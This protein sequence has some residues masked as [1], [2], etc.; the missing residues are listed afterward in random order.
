M[1]HI[2]EQKSNHVMDVWQWACTF[3]TH[4]SLTIMSNHNV[5]FTNIKYSSVWSPEILK[6]ELNE[7]HILPKTWQ[8]SHIMMLAGRTVELITAP[9][10]FMFLWLVKSYLVMRLFPQ[11]D[12][13]GLLNSVIFIQY[14]APAH[15]AAYMCVC[16]CVSEQYSLQTGQTR[17]LCWLLEAVI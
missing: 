4:T 12:N 17:S 8:H 1:A 15:Y 5:V 7:F 16:V 13:A 11:L 9:Y 14:G 6:C 2:Y 10:F 3:L